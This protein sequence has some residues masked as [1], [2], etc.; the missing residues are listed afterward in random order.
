MTHVRR[1][2]AVLLVSLLGLLAP[3]QA[4]AADL[5]AANKAGS[6]V[7]TQV[8]GGQLDD[9]FDPI[10]A[11]TDGLI[12]LA[13]TNDPAL[14]P[15]IDT[16]LATVRANAKT[17]ATS[18][19]RAAKLAL[20][21]EA[22]GDDPASFGG[23]DLVSV[24]KAGVNADGSIG[25]T[26]GAFTQGLVM[27]GLE[28]AGAPVPASTGAWLA[29]AA[30]SDGGY[31]YA[32]GQPSDADSTGMAIYGLA[33][34]K[35][36]VA[37]ASA[38]GWAKAH[39][40][41]DG[42]WAGYVPANSTAVLG[43]ALQA[44]GQ[45]VT[46]A[47]A[48]LLSQQLA[49]GAITDGTGANLMATTQGLPLLGSTNYRDVTWQAAT[50]APSPTASPTTSAAPTAS[51]SATPTPSATPSASTTS[52]RPAAGS[53]GRGVP[54]RTGVEDDGAWPLALAA[55]LLAAGAVLAGRRP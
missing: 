54:A 35:S 32:A 3:T 37:L 11:S 18:P 52:E 16:L 25:A 5:T 46:K 8:S 7:A 47:R 48:Y 10:G 19:G 30:N 41:A 34:A 38:I 36:N 42:S 6:W 1:L 21:A 53:T 50:I 14:K 40:A 26:P 13:A 24:M 29:A 31:G 39:Q 27:L 4:L 12:G 55:V 20:V 17:Y 44:A 51:V 43:S 15:T 49:S 2:F 28:R 9:G 22:Y 23:V 33:A 45:D